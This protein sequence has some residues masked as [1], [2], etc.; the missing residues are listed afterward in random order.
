M[1]NWTQLTA[2]GRAKD[3]GI[4]WTE[5][6]QEAL[7]TL[8]KHSGLERAEIA[9]FVR[10]GVLTVEAYEAAIGS[11]KKPSSRSELEERAKEAGVSFDAVAPDSVLETAT[12]KKLKSKK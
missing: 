8:I 1:L 10:E 9:R 7:A 2:Q 6:E 12:A 4:A 5:E 3:I 11:G